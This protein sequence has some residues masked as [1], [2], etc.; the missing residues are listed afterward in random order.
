MKI[1]RNNNSFPRVGIEF[2][3]DALQSDLCGPAPRRPQQNLQFGLTKR[4]QSIKIVELLDQVL[5]S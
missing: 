2:T 4:V 3:T 1:L 5:N